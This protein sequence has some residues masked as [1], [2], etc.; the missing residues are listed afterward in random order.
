ME[1]DKIKLT[2]VTPELQELTVN[3]YTEQGGIGNQDGETENS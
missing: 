3:Q 2:W 1:N